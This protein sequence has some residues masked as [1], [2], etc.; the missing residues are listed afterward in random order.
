RHAFGEVAAFDRNL[1]DLLA[2]VGRANLDLDLFCSCLAD[3]DPVVATYVVDERIIE[4]GTADAHGPGV[5]DACQGD[6][7]DLRS[8]VADVEH[9]RAAGLVHRQAGADCSRH[10]LLAETHPSRACA[11]CGF[12]DRT[13]LDL[14]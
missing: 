7:S 5:H 13:T 1:F 4:A 8:S 6:D 10:R 3:Q 14:R 9:H 2:G 12:L 11:F